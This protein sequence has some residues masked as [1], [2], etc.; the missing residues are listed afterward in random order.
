VY[1]Q[2]NWVGADNYL[3]NQRP[4]GGKSLKFDFPIDLT[5]GPKS[6]INATTSNL[7]YWNNIM[8]DVFYQY[9]FDEVAGNFQQD[10]GKKGGAG[11]DAV[12]ANAQDGSGTDNANFATPPDGQHGTMRMYVFDNTEPN[13]DGDLESD[14]ISHEYTHGISNRLTGGPANSDCLDANESGGMG[15]G[16]SDF[17]AITLQMKAADTRTKNVAVGA[18]VNEGKTI[19]RYNYSTDIKANPTMYGLLNSGWDEVHDI[20]EIWCNVLYEVYWNLMD[21]TKKY[22][23]DW[24]SADKTAGNTLALQV[25]LDGMKLQPCNPTFVSAR[26]AILQAEK[27]VTGGKYQCDIWKAFAKRGVGFGAKSTGSKVTQSVKLPTTCP[28]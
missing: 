17:F 1:A 20:G 18:W 8:H 6:Y 12:I 2:E 9:G 23:P 24:Y 4:D 27:Q 16:W 25:V 19:R 11:D 22:N 13:R 15:E 21:A 14:I 10:N 7:F 28:K 5:Q 26:D 3:D